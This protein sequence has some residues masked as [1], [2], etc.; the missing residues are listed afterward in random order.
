MIPNKYKTFFLLPRMLG[1]SCIKILHRWMRKRWRKGALIT[2]IDVMQKWVFSSIMRLLSRARAYARSQESTSF[3]SQTAYV[4]YTEH[5][6][7]VS[8]QAQEYLCGGNTIC[9]KLFVST[10]IYY[11]RLHYQTDK[12]KSN[13]GVCNFLHLSEMILW[14][15][16]WPPESLWWRHFCIKLLASISI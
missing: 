2:S 10:S 15:E 14:W 4:K 5:D 12:H 1:I 16:F 7:T 6:V 13:Y 11:I 3:S 8:C 9:I